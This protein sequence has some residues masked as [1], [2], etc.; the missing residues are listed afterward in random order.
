M[1]KGIALIE[2]KS[3]FPGRNVK[4]AGDKCQQ[5]GQQV[6][7]LITK[8]NHGRL[9]ESFFLLQS[10]V[11]NIMNAIVCSIAH[12]QFSGVTLYMEVTQE[13]ML[14]MVESRKLDINNILDLGQVR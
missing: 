14:P 6:I 10:R 11:G 4:G 3:I 13:A 2:S 7:D 9:P 5:I 12:Q 1:S 8:I